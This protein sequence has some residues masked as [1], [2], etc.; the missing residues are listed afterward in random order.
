MK[1]PINLLK[2]LILFPQ[3]CWASSYSITDL[4]WVG[5]PASIFDS[6]DSGSATG[7]MTAYH[8]NTTAMYFDG[9]NFSNIGNLENIN[10]Y[11]SSAR[12]I[13]SSNQVTGSSDIS[14]YSTIRSRAFVWDNGTF[15]D[16][17]VLEG[18]ES[19]GGRDIN[20]SGVVVGTMHTSKGETRGFIYENGVMEQLMGLNGKHI[21]P[22]AI[23]NLGQFV[24]TSSASV[25]S[26]HAFIGSGSEIQD[27]GTLGGNHSWAIHIND[28]G[29]VVGGAE[30]LQGYRHAFIWKDGVMSDLGTLGGFQSQAYSINSMNQVVG[31][32]ENSK[33]IGE[34]FLYRD[35]EMFSLCGLVNCESYGW[36]S[37]NTYTINNNGEIFGTGYLDGSYHAFVVTPV[38]ITSAIWLFGSGLVGIIGISR[39]RRKS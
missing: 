29:A 39:R 4:G 25:E 35:G 33:N 30:T 24:G 13:N 1:T 28:L 8:G 10:Y 7:Q 14:Y 31:W 27:L 6:N 5:W 23:N 18:H 12:G 37:L 16:L 22:F 9:A 15:T 17:G 2:I 32:A 34:A 20:D 21:E 26:T 19:S 36:G 3:L 11:T 38:P